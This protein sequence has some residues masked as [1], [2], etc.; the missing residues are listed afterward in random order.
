[1]LLRPT[2]CKP[3][4]IV[5]LATRRGVRRLESTASRALRDEVEEL[6]AVGRFHF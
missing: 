1:M 4:S 5:R 2:D 6:A 3:H